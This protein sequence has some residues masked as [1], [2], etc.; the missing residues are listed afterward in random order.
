MGIFN[1]NLEEKFTVR[2][3]FENN[4]YTVIQTLVK[5]REKKMSGLA[6]VTKKTL[7]I[8]SFRNLYSYKLSK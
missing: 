6:T 3:F 1:K 5:M 2:E 8:L 7:F 4:G